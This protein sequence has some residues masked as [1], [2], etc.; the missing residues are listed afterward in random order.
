MCFQWYFDFNYELT[1]KLK[2][3]KTCFQWYFDFNNE[4]TLKLKYEKKC[5]FNGISILIMN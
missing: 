2:Y 3:E 5:V 4:L 1:L